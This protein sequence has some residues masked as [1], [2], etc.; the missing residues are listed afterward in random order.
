MKNGIW[1]SRLGGEKAESSF[2]QH[3]MFNSTVKKRSFGHNSTSRMSSNGDY[4]KILNRKFKISRDLSKYSKELDYKR[5]ERKLLAFSK[6]AKGKHLTD[7]RKR[8]EL[9]SEQET[10][11]NKERDA[12]KNTDWEDS[13][14]FEAYQESKQLR[15]PIEK[16][17]Q[18]YA[19]LKTVV[20]DKMYTDVELQYFMQLIQ[21]K[22]CKTN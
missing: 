10:K 9:V 14:L 12:L 21:R 19:G 20:A 11:W 2:S 1:S 22:D 8:A 6:S 18:R 7:M 4:K 3:S 17:L 5:T 16:V 13:D 15:K